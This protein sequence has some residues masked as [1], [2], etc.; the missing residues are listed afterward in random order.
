MDI[1]FTWGD[2]AD[3]DAA[4]GTA[5]SIIAKATALA[6]SCNVY[7]PYLYQNYAYITQDVLSSYG[8]ESKQRLL[9][10]QRNHDPHFV[11]RDLQ[12]GY[13]KLRA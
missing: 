1:D 12:P 8:P 11:F 13:F 2:P 7:H 9:R 4:Q 6:K 5:R 3:D 10:I